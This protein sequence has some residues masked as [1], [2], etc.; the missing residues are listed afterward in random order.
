MQIDLSDTDVPLV[1]RALKLYAALEASH[2][3][4]ERPY[5]ELAER[6]ESENAAERKPP[7]SQEIT[8][9]KRRARC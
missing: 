2:N 9:Q 3:R 6:L 7:Q 4:D 8:V 1:I 5:R